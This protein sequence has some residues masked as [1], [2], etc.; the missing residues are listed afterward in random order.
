MNG[1]SSLWLVHSMQFLVWN[2][3]HRRNI[4][5][6][7]APGAPEP[8]IVPP[9]CQEPVRSGFPL[10]SLGVGAFG[11]TWAPPPRPPPKPPPPPPGGPPCPPPPRCASRDRTRQPSI[12]AVVTSRVPTRSCFLMTEPLSSNRPAPSEA[13]VRKC[14]TSLPGLPSA[15]YQARAR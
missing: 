10:A 3:V 6:T 8:V 14:V 2:G 13:P 4:S 11:S 12:A 9:A 1:Q 7:C 15:H 5:P